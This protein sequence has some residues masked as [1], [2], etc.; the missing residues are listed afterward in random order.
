MENFNV[1]EFHHTRD[2]SKKMNAT[3]E[4][5]RQNFKT[6]GKSILFIA[7]PPVLVASMMIGS[8]IGEFFNLTQSAAT[9]PWRYRAFSKLF[10]VSE[11]LAS[12]CHGNGFFYRQRRDD[13]CHDK[14]LPHFVW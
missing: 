14:Q 9:K 3:F 4:F 5:I 8:F 10:H 11:F 12:N 1:I 2:F 6:L 13:Y 7:G